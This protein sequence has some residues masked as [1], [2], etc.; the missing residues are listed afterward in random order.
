VAL[1]FFIKFSGFADVC[2]PLNDMPKYF[3][4]LYCMLLF[5][6]NDL[7]LFKQIILTGEL[8]PSTLLYLIFDQQNSSRSSVIGM[9]TI[10]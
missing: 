4:V 1:V 9:H 6:R 5:V 3:F 10:Y 8:E 2:M 7:R